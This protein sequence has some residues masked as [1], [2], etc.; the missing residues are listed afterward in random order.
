MRI[1]RFR[2]RFPTWLHKTKECKKHKHTNPYVQ[3][4]IQK[5]SQNFE[6]GCSGKSNT[7]ERNIELWDKTWKYII[8]YHL[9]QWTR[10]TDG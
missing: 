4:T 2:A 9:Q 3:I 5:Q 1:K 8:N 6:G 10:L 7:H